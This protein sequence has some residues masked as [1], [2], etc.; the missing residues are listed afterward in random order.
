VSVASSLITAL[1]PAGL[2]V[3]QT[4][5]TG[6]ASTYL[7]FNYITEP[8]HFADDSPNYEQYSIQVHLIAPKTTN[9]TTLQ[10]TIKSALASN[11]YDYPRTINASDDEEEQ[12]IVFETGIEEYVGES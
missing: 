7:T 8:Q 10:A 4:Q 1:A 2:P 12:H 9:T 3:Q 5:Y 6:T 11:G